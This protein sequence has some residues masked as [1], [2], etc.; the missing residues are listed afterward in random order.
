[1][2]NKE[3]VAISMMVALFVDGLEPILACTIRPSGERPRQVSNQWSLRGSDNKKLFT[4][5]C[6]EGHRTIPLWDK[7]YLG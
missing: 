7:L 4:D 2:L 5:G 6:I 3:E 1:M